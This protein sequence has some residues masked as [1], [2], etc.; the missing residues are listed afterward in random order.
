MLR[1]GLAG[2][3][4]RSDRHLQELQQRSSVEIVGWLLPVSDPIPP[5]VTESN[6]TVFHTPEQFVA[7]T[8]LILIANINSDQFSFVEYCLKEGKHVWI[9]LPISLTLEECNR[10]MNRAKESNVTCQVC[11]AY[12]YDPALVQVRQA[13]QKPLFIETHRLETLSSTKKYPTDVVNDLMVYDLQIIMQLIDSEIKRVSATGVKVWNE[14]LDIANARIEF[15]NG[16]IANLTSSRIALKHYTKMRI[17]QKDCYHV[18]DFIEHRSDRV[19]LNKQALRAEEALQSTTE[20]STNHSA[21]QLMYDVLLRNLE[22][23]SVGD[24]S[25]VKMYQAINLADMIVKRINNL[26]DD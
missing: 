6:A 16:T 22:E 3:N 9:D 26:N 4:E 24:L 20:I 1:V 11:N 5:I 17:F 13:V 23:N 25:F 14:A 2:W 15:S 10:L 18:I 7:E 8:Q 21:Y 12:F 19:T